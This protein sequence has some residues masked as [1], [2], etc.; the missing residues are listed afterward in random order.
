MI[1]S[2]VYQITIGVLG[3][4]CLIMYLLLKQSYADNVTLKINNSKLENSLKMQS[5]TIDYLKDSTTNLNETLKILAKANDNSTYQLSVSTKEINELR[6][7]EAKRA[8]EN[9]Y[10]R[11]NFATDMLSKR[12]QSI[13]R[14]T[15]T[16]SN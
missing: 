4:G 13:T 12:L 11:G 6:S 7:K 10:E 9:P 15:N 8:I 14:K 2:R 16:D 1:F 3:I 5:E